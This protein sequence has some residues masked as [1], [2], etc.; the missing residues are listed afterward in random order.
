MGKVRR[1]LGQILE[2]WQGKGFESMDPQSTSWGMA[3]DKTEEADHV[4]PCTE[5]KGNNRR[6]LFG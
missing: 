3:R 4:G 1:K 6:I 5:I 2:F